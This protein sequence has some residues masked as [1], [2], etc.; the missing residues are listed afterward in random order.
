MALDNP[1]RQ[2]FIDAE[3]KEIQS[4]LNMGTYNPNEQIPT[5]I[6][7]NLIGTSKFV[8]TKKYHPDDTFG[9]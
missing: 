9:I 4:I 2:G 1:D 5:N 6:N 7:K 3:K 8:Y